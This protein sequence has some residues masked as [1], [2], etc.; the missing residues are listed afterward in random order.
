MRMEANGGQ[1]DYRFAYNADG[2][3]TSKTIGGQEHRYLLNGS[4]IVTETWTTKS[5]SGAETPNHFLVYLY[6]ENGAPVGLQYRNKSDAKNV[7]YTYYFE[8]N[9]QGDIIAIYTE[10]GTK[11]GSYTYDAWG[12]CTISTES[13]TTTIQKR[14]VRTLNPFRYRGYYYDYDTGLYYLQS[15]YYVPQW[16]RF[17]NADGYVS[18]GTGLLGYNMYAYCD[19]N[20]AMKTDPYGSWPK[21]L[22]EFYNNAKIWVGEHIVKPV[23]TFCGNVKE[24]IEKYDKYNDSEEKVLESHYFSSYK[25]VLVLRTNGKRSGSF[26]VIFLTYESSERTYPEDVVR[27]E[28]GHTVQLQQLGIVKYALCIGLPSWLE[29]GSKDYYDKPWE[30]TADLFGG[31]QSREASRS[32]KADA[33]HYLWLSKQVGPFAWRT[34]D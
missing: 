11:I 32:D 19:N 3:L 18:T 2:I 8:K 31:V 29:W 25:G 4:Q 6:D 33:F 28:Y 10:N 30:V 7:F 26:G 24:D 14:I 21:W 15:R 13:G 27:H 22:D 1:S 5:S 9:L 16:G 34:I 23:E 12:N 20:P 17:L